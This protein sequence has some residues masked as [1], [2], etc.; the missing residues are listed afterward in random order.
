MDLT[1]IIGYVCNIY[2]KPPSVRIFL[3]NFFIDEFE[4]NSTISIDEMKLY[5]PLDERDNKI[6]GYKSDPLNPSKP[7]TCKNIDQS[8]NLKYYNLKNLPINNES[9]LCVR[10]EVDNNDSNYTNGFITQSTMVSF[11]IISLLST[12]TFQNWHEFSKR[13]LLRLKKLREKH[14]DIQSIKKHYTKKG[15]F[16][17]I[18]RENFIFYK[19]DE[20]KYIYSNMCGGSGKFEIK[21][22]KK[23][24]NII[25]DKSIGIKRLGQ[26]QYISA[27]LNKYLQYENQ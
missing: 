22:Y 15:L 6:F 16:F 1:L 19:N 13:Y 27:L 12:K 24:F 20:K 14:Q 17:A 21:F 18:R 4:C 3:N 5:R 10:I 26:W 11:P 2:K 8:V 9:L 25:C 7:L 23:Y